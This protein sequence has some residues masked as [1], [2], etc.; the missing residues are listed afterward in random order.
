LPFRHRGQRPRVFH[1]IAAYGNS[2]VIA[3]IL[4]L[5]TNPLAE[6]P[7]RRLIKKKRL[8]GHLKKIYK[9]VQALH[10]RQFVCDHRFELSRRKA[11]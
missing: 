6:P 2:H 10:M 7:H 5:G 4:A 9:S 3:A 8:G 11:R 1:G